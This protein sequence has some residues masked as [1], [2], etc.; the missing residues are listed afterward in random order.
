MNSAAKIRFVQLVKIFHE[1]KKESIFHTSLI[2]ETFKGL[3]YVLGTDALELEF[4]RFWQDNEILGRFL[5]EYLDRLDR[6]L[7][8]SQIELD[9]VD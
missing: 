4:C 3:T 2:K 5:W 6:V 8:A 9:H 7:I 1:V